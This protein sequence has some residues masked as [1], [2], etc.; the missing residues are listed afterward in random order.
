MARVRYWACCS[1]SRRP[2]MAHATIEQRADPSSPD[3]DFH[4]SEPSAY[5][6]IS[7]AFSSTPLGSQSNRLRAC[8]GTASSARLPSC[9]STAAAL[10]G[11]ARWCPCPRSAARR[12]GVPRAFGSACAEQRGGRGGFAPR[13]PLLSPHASR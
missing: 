3:A 1:G 13:T 6:S 11:R 2:H 12:S 9:D 7:S 4:C 8:A 5:F 10:C